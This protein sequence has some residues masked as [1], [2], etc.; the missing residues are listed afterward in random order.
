[1]ACHFQMTHAHVYLDRVILTTFS[2]VRIWIG[3]RTLCAR[4]RKTG[5]AK[6]DISLC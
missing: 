2:L 6:I 3:A 4:T 5:R 1:M